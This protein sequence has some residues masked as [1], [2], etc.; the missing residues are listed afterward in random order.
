MKMAGKIN[1]AIADDHVPFREGLI[2]LLERYNDLK[3]LFDVDNGLQVM[4]K[5]KSQTP[6]IIL[7]DLDMGGMS[8]E[9]TYDLIVQKYPEIC[10]II[11]TGHFNDSFVVRFIKKEVPCILSKTVP[12]KKIV[13]AIR[14][15][16]LNGKYFDEA[17]SAIMAKSISDSANEKDAVERP[18]LDLNFQEIQVLKLMCL[19][20][21]S[22]KI[23]EK[24]HRSE[25]TVDYN[26]NCIW[27]KTKIENKSIS[28]L[29]LF[30]LKHKI[31]T[32]M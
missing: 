15:V 10:V 13:E 27:R 5:L 19:G 20:F 7:M 28:E 30:A 4:E 6:D 17:V 14:A 16:H 11:L 24:L 32:I 8:G 31:V 1:I 23:A 25:R 2:A 29:I 3:I 18:E 12:T 21:S 26:R 22:K 9:E